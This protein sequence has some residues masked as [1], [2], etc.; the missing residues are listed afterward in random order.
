MERRFLSSLRGSWIGILPKVLLGITPSTGKALAF[1]LDLMNHRKALRKTPALKH[2]KKILA[3]E[4]EV[5]SN[6][7]INA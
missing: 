4:Q 1:Y 7:L 2:F 5:V 6:L 3:E